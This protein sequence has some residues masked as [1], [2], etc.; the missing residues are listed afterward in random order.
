MRHVVKA[1]LGTGF[2][3]ALIECCLGGAPTT[4][5]A[6]TVTEHQAT[7]AT[8]RRLDACQRLGRQR[9]GMRALVL[10]PLGR[11]FD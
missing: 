8:G 9:H 2:G 1:S 3:N 7:V 5:P 11:K 10:N 6:G 4:K